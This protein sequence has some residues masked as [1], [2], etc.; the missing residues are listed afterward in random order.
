MVGTGIPVWPVEELKEKAKIIKKKYKCFIIP[1][2]NDLK[3][4]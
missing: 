3:V 4:D 2:L 1:N